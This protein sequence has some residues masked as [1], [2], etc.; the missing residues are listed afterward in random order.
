MLVPK[1]RQA[2]EERRLGVNHFVSVLVGITFFSHLFQVRKDDHEYRDLVIVGIH[3]DP[4]IGILL[5]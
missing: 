5:F 3:E 2:T 1:S 4:S